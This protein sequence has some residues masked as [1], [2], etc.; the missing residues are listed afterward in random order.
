VDQENGVDKGGRSS[1]GVCFGK[2]SRRTKAKNGTQRI[3]V[4]QNTKKPT[5]GEVSS[6]FFEV[7]RPR[8]SKKKGGKGRAPQ[9]HQREHIRGK[10]REKSGGDRGKITRHAFQIGPRGWS[11]R[12]G[13][14]VPS[15]GKKKKLQVN[16]KTALRKKEET[17]D[18]KSGRGGLTQ[19]FQ[20]QG[21]GYTFKRT[22]NKVIHKRGGNETNVIPNGAN[23]KKGK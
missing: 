10:G 9:G 19:D 16:K 14:W 7:I 20:T 5:G 11:P 18:L 1:P 21:G 23:G 13:E 4:G 2:K 17:L 22:C 6:K 8:K 3:C 15:G 12:N